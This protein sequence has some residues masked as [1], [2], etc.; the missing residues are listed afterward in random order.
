MKTGK[1]FIIVLISIFSTLPTFAAETSPY[2]FLRYVSGARAASLAGS[3]V[4]IENDASAVVYNPGAIYTVSDKPL[5]ATFLKHVLDI[6][7]GLAVYVH[8]LEDGAK[9]AGAIGFN[10][11]GAFT[12]ADK[13]GNLTS[14]FG[15]SDISAAL[16]Y[17]DWIDSSLYYG[18]GAKFIFVNLEEQ[19]FTAMAIDAGL[20]YQMN[21]RTNIGLSVLH[22]GMQLSGIEGVDNSLPLDIRAGIN[23]RLRGLPL[24]INFSFHFLYPA[25]LFLEF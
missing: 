24:L 17:S 18:A 22:A 7:S 19:S 6:N 25:E 1:L 9:L 23:H 12:G 13:F 20:F 4:S 5:H 16:Y 14:E 8:P 3:F 11:Y 2:Q 10:S 15:G 21:D